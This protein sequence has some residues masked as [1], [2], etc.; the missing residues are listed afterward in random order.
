MVTQ[1]NYKTLKRS[2][3][4]KAAFTPCGWKSYLLVPSESGKDGYKDKQM[5][6]YEPE[7]R[8]SVLVYLLAGVL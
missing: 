7:A 5:V 4:Y 1:S 8:G 6:G 2:N 3:E